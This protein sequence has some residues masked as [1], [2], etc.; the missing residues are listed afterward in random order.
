VAAVSDDPEFYEAIAGQV[1][2]AQATFGRPKPDWYLFPFCDRVRLRYGSPG[3]NHQDFMGK[4]ARRG[5]GG[6]P[7]S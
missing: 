7:L 5:E 1:K 3:Q 4:R 6:L 2:L